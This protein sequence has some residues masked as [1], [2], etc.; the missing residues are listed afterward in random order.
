MNSS[1]KLFPTFFASLLLALPLAA[2]DLPTIKVVGVA[3]ERVPP[4]QL[5]VSCTIRNTGRQ[6]AEVAAS[7]RARA[8]EVTKILRDLGLGEAELKTGLASFG[9]KTEYKDGHHIRLGY[10]ATTS[11][12]VSTSKLELYDPIWLQLSKFPEVSINSA[13]FGLQDRAKVRATARKKAIQAARAKAEEMA[14]AL[15]ARIGAPLSLIEIPQ[16]SSPLAPNIARNSI[17]STLSAPVRDSPLEPGLISVVE[18]VEATFELI[19]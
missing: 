15:D 19:E 1:P 9:E 12:T 16:R 11:I 13:E 2:E 14:D 8:A 18:H 10:Q 4:D 7:N 6:L 5:G 17:D 3:E